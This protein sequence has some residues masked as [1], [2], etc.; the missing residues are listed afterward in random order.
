[1]SLVDLCF[2]DTCCYTIEWRLLSSVD[3]EMRV[4]LLMPINLDCV[5]YSRQVILQRV[6]PK[7]IP[8]SRVIDRAAVAM[9][10][11]EL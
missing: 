2:F 5:G 1:M 9:R 6:G 10:L 4:S 7:G 3:H 8:C 11:I